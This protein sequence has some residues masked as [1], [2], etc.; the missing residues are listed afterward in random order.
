MSC[1]R[2]RRDQVGTR[3]VAAVSSGCVGLRQTI[4]TG[5]PARSAP[6]AADAQRGIAKL[7]AVTHVC[8][9]RRIS[10][11]SR[12]QQRCRPPRARAAAASDGCRLHAC[13]SRG[14]APT[15][16][17]PS[18]RS[19]SGSSELYCGGHA[20]HLGDRCHAPRRPCVSCVELL[21]FAAKHPAAETCAPTRSPA[22]MDRA[23]TSSVC[24]NAEE[25]PRT[26]VSAATP[27]ATDKDDEEELA[28]RRT[29]LA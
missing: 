24:R 10:R 26:P 8:N 20:G 1:A 16:R 19:S 9:F 23:R 18:P 6:S 5:G 17:R 2:A 13:R 28:A 7:D 11:S 25:K 3:P 21:C 15:Y 29:Q 14:T 27:M 4:R 22:R 12:R